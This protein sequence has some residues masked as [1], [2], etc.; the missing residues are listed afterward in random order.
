MIKYRNKVFSFT[1]NS[2]ESWKHKWKLKTSIE[3][4]KKSQQKKKK[5]GSS[6]LFPSVDPIV[7]TEK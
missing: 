5:K 6:H 2:W 1:K 7:H 3:N 4:T